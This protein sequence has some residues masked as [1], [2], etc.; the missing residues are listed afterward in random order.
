MK[1]LATSHESAGSVSPGAKQPAAGA[2]EATSR[3]PRE[4]TPA[5]VVAVDVTIDAELATVWSF[6][7]DPERF[8]LWIGAFAGM[9]PLPGTRIDPRVGGSI[10]V[11]YP[12]GSLAQG[13]ITA[14]EPQRRIEF[15]WGYSGGPVTDM[16]PGSTRVEIWLTPTEFGTHV[17]LRHYGIPTEEARQGHRGGWTHYLTMLA[18]EA[19]AAQRSPTL[20]GIFAD[21]FAAWGEPDSARRLALLE[22]SCD[23]MVQ[24]R[25]QYACTDSL[26]A[27]SEHMANAQRHMPG[28]SL[29]M[30]GAPQA[31]HGYARVGWEVATPDGQIVMSGENFARQALNGR[32]RALASFENPR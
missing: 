7:S 27:L 9:P 11:E 1:R 23:A 4:S 5:D 20:A 26:A 28:L 24:V 19:S 25:T 17:E 3:S 30:R 32:I 29:R 10:A 6:L 15:T 14:V 21:Y 16:P 31:L 18:R 2:R 8:R 22:R 12:G 13:A